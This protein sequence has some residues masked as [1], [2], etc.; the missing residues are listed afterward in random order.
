MSEVYP[1]FATHITS[2]LHCLFHRYRF[3]T[4]SLHRA[5]YKCNVLGYLKPVR[6]WATLL[7]PTARLYR[8]L[9]IYHPL[10]IKEYELVAPQHTLSEY[11]AECPVMVCGVMYRVITELEI[12]GPRINGMVGQFVGYQTRELG[13]S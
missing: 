11:L 9:G 5:T 8:G 1:Y 3:H 4:Y 6:L 13:Q 12:P 2:F 7:C 10:Y